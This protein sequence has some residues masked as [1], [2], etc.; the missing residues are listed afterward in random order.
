MIEGSKHRLSWADA[1]RIVLVGVLGALI[2]LGLGDAVGTTGNLGPLDV[3]TRLTVGVGSTFDVGVAAVRLDTP[4]PIGLS[5]TAND[6]RFTDPGDLAD[7]LT[8]FGDVGAVAATLL[9]D[10]VSQLAE[11]ASVGAL[12]GLLLGLAS[13]RRVLGH[14]PTRRQRRAVY[15][16][17][18]WLAVGTL[19]TSIIGPSVDLA[20]RSWTP[21]VGL[22]VEGQVV[23]DVQV[24]GNLL[25]ETVRV[26]EE[27]ENFY[28]RL[29]TRTATA[30]TEIADEDAER[31]LATFV[32]ESD[33]HC[34]LGMT[35]VISEVASQSQASFVLSGG[36]ITMSG[37]QLEALCTDVY[38]RRLGGM[39][40]VLVLGNHDSDQTGADLDAGGAAVMHGE[41]IGVAGLT[42][43]GDSDPYRSQI[44]AST[45]LRGVE[46]AKEFTNRTAQAACDTHPDVLVVHDPAQAALAITDQCAPLV[47]SGHRHHEEGPTVT[48]DTVAYT[49]DNSGGT[50]E[51]TPSY[52]PLATDS[53]V[54]V[55]YYDPDSAVVLGFRTVAFGRDGFVGV[56]DYRLLNP[57]KLN[58]GD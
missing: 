29:R 15:A 9:G 27:N 24:A 12:G 28:E 30:M 56:G 44:G 19:A 55:F 4:G 33:L 51:N 50:G 47:L 36:D 43:L 1:A 3:T 2:G 32:F 40:L 41:P 13:H 52:G 22:S 7:T 35:R 6:V 17:G 48:E 31:G 5:I 23:P 58:R 18:S 38:Q 34:N 20:S 49:V 16:A 8:S 46:T 53:A 39:P 26:L 10:T 42:L 57:G 21:V 25:D 11:F 14:R 45:T 54:A 37:T